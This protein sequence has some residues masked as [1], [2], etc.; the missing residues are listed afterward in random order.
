MLCEV[1][2]GGG[3]GEMGCVGALLEGM[4]LLV[5]E[6]LLEAVVCHLCE[7]RGEK[8]RHIRRTIGDGMGRDGIEIWDRDYGSGR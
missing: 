8:G 2:A 5:E 3:G 6:G 1:E 4:V 7:T